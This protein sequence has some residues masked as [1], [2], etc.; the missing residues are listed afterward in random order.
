MFVAL[1][2]SAVDTRKE[3]FVDGEFEP[4]SLGLPEG[5]RT[6]WKRMHLATE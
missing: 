1:A 6:A 2:L 5:E 3:W 4:S